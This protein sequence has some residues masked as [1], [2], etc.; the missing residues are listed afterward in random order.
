[1]RKN[2]LSR[3]LFRITFS[4]VSFIAIAIINAAPPDISEEYAEVKDRFSSNSAQTIYFI[5][6]AHCNAEAQM[7]IY[8]IINYLIE[9]KSVELITM[10][11]AEGEIKPDDLRK[12]PYE[13]TKKLVSN[14][15]VKNG[16]I[17][18]VEYYAINDPNPVK[19]LGIEDRELYRKNYENLV[20]VLKN[21]DQGAV[22]DQL[23]KIIKLIKHKIYS[24]ELNELEFLEQSFD[25]NTL[26][27]QDYISKI[28]VL[29]VKKGISPGDYVNLQKC[30]EM[31]Q[32]EKSL[33][34]SAIENERARLVR[35][36]TENMGKDEISEFLQEN[37]KFRLSKISYLN[38]LDYLSK[39]SAD[40]NVDY[41]GFLQ[42]N[43]YQKYLKLHEE[44]NKDRIFVESDNLMERLFGL[45]CAKDSQR[46]IKN[47]AQQAKILR[48]SF[49]LNLTS[50]EWNRL[51]QE[52]LF[53]ENPEDRKFLESYGQEKELHD[54]FAKISEYF[55][56]VKDFYTCAEKRDMVLVENTL[57]DMEKLG[58]KNAVIVAGGYH[59][60]GIAEKLK[61]KN[62]SHYV[63]TA[64]LT[65]EDK[66]NPYTSIVFGSENKLEKFLAGK[67]DA[68]ALSSWLDS[69]PLVVPENKIVFG[70]MFKS[71]LFSTLAWQMTGYDIPSIREL[72]L[73]VLQSVQLKLNE[74]A[75][76]VGYD[77]KVLEI[78]RVN[79]QVYVRL[80]IA[81]QELVYGLF[82]QRNRVSWSS[83]RKAKITSENVLTN[84]QL[85]GGSVLAITPDQYRAIIEAAGRKAV[86]LPEGSDYV[87]RSILTHPFSAHIISVLAV[88]ALDG[89]PVSDIPNAAQSI[90]VSLS[91]M[92]YDEDKSSIEDYLR[93]LIDQF[94]KDGNLK[95]ESGKIKFGQKTV[96]AADI[97]AKVLNQREGIL[98]KINDLMGEIPFADG[99]LQYVFAGNFVPLNILEAL[100]DIKDKLSYGERVGLG[101][102]GDDEFTVEVHKLAGNNYFALITGK[103]RLPEF[104]SLDEVY[105][106]VLGDDTIEVASYDNLGLLIKNISPTEKGLYFTLV[107]Q[108][109]NTQESAGPIFEF[110]LEKPK[111]VDD[112]IDGL[113]NWK[114]KNSV[115]IVTRIGAFQEKYANYNHLIRSVFEPSANDLDELEQVEE[116]KKMIN[117]YIFAAGK[118]MQKTLGVLSGRI[119][120][121]MQGKNPR[122]PAIKAIL[123]R[124]AAFLGKE[125]K[126]DELDL[127]YHIYLHYLNYQAKD[128][129]IKSIDPA[130]LA[131]VIK[132][133]YI[134][135]E[136]ITPDSAQEKLI[137]SL[138]GGK[139]LSKLDF[140]S[141]S[142]KM[143]RDYIS[144]IFS[145][146][147]SVDSAFKNAGLSFFN[148]KRILVSKSRLGGFV[149]D[150][151]ILVE[152]YQGK[153]TILRLRI[154]N[155][156]TLSNLFSRSVNSMQHKT[157]EHAELFPKIYYHHSSL[158]KTPVPVDAS[159]LNYYFAQHVDGIVGD[160]ITTH[161]EEFTQT[162]ILSMKFDAARAWMKFWD[163][164]RQPKTSENALDGSNVILPATMESVMF[165]D[166]GADPMI[167]GIGYSVQTDPVTFFDLLY[168]LIAGL[169]I[170]QNEFIPVFGNAII[171]IFGFE[172]GQELL[173]QALAEYKHNLEWYRSGKSDISFDKIM[174]L[175]RY[176][177][178]SKKLMNRDSVVSLVDVAYGGDQLEAFKH[179]S[180]LA[181]K[182]G[183]MTTDI[184]TGLMMKWKQKNPSVNEAKTMVRRNRPSILTITGGTGGNS[185][186]NA[187]KGL[188]G[189]V[190][191]LVS[192]FDSG[193]QSY[194]WQDILDP[195]FGYVYSRGDVT[196]VSIAYLDEA[197]QDLLNK[198]LPDDRDID[199][200]YPIVGEIIAPTLEKYPQI[201]ESP[202]FLINFIDVVK[203]IDEFIAFLRTKHKEN[204]EKYR[205]ID[206]RKA[207]I[208][209]LFDESLNYF[210]N[211]Y[212]VENGR[213]DMDKNAVAIY[214]AH[215]LLGIDTGV[216]LPISTDEGDLVA[217]L[218]TPI[219]KEE[220][221]ELEREMS[222]GTRLN[223]NLIPQDGTSIFGEHYIGEIGDFIPQFGK[224]IDYLDNVRNPS[225]QDQKP[226]MT[227]QALEA[228][229]YPSLD[230]IMVGP[231]SLFT[232]LLANFTLKEF[233]DGLVNR[234]KSQV[235]TYPN[236]QRIVI[237]PV[238]R[239][240]IMNPVHSPEDRGMSVTDIILMIERTAQKSTGNPSLKFEDM[241]DAVI[242]NDP[243]KSNDIVKEFIRKKNMDVIAPTADDEQFLKSRDIEVYSF[244]MCTIQQRPTRKAGFELA[245]ADKL[246]YSSET[247]KLIGNLFL[248]NV[249][250]Q[251]RE[252]RIN[253]G[254]GH[255][256][257][258][259]EDLERVKN[260]IQQGTVKPL[261]Y[262]S[263]FYK[264]GIQWLEMRL[265]QLENK[266]NREE[267][268]ETIVKLR[269][270]LD[271]FRK[272]LDTMNEKK[273]KIFSI[274]PKDGSKAIFI[275]DA[276]H[277]QFSALIE[278]DEKGLKHGIYLSQGLINTVEEYIKIHNQLIE[279]GNLELSDFYANKAGSIASES[280]FQPFAEWT[281]QQEIQGDFDLFPV[282]K[283]IKQIGEEHI[284]IKRPI[285]G[286]Y[287]Y[288]EM[289]SI[290]GYELV[291]KNMENIYSIIGVS[292]D[293]SIEEKI[294]FLTRMLEKA[295]KTGELKSQLNGFISKLSV[296]MESLLSSIHEIAPVTRDIF[297]DLEIMA[298]LSS[299]GFNSI[300]AMMKSYVK[301][302]GKLDEVFLNDIDS[303]ILY[304]YWISTNSM[305]D[306]IDLMKKE[307]N[308]RLE[309]MESV[310]Q[311]PYLQVSEEL[312][313]FRY[314]VGRLDKM[315]S[316]LRSD[317]EMQN[318]FN[319]LRKVTALQIEETLR[320]LYLQKSIGEASIKTKHDPDTLELAETRYHLSAMKTTELETWMESAIIE[321]ISPIKEGFKGNLKQFLSMFDSMMDNYPVLRD[322][323]VKG[324]PIDATPDQINVV[325][326]LL[327]I[328]IMRD[329]M[330]LAN[331]TQIINFGNALYHP[332][333]T[334]LMIS[335]SNMIS[336]EN[337]IMM[338]YLSFSRNLL[339]DVEQN[340]LEIAKKISG[341]QQKYPK[342]FERFTNILTKRG[343]LIAK[344]IG[345]GDGHHSENPLQV[346]KIILG[347]DVKK[348][349][350]S[351]PLIKGVKEYIHDV[352]LKLMIDSRNSQ[353]EEYQQ[354]QAASTFLFRIY[355]AMD[356]AQ[357]RFWVADPKDGNPGIFIADKDHFQFAS[358]VA[359]DI[360]FSK[361]LIDRL[362]YIWDRGQVTNAVSMMADSIVNLIG[363]RIIQDDMGDS[364]DPKAVHELM[365][366][367]SNYLTTKSPVLDL[368]Q[369]PDNLVF[370]EMKKIVDAYIDFGITDTKSIPLFNYPGDINKLHQQ[371]REK[372]VMEQISTHD[373][374]NIVLEHYKM[375]A[376]LGAPE[377]I[378]FNNG[379]YHPGEVLGRIS[380][381]PQVRGADVTVTHGP[382]AEKIIDLSETDEPSKT[383]AREVIHTL[384]S[385]NRYR[386]FIGT[387]TAH[388]LEDMMYDI[389][390]II[391]TDDNPYE[392]LKEEYN[393]KGM[394]ALKEIENMISKTNDELWSAILVAIAGNALDFADSKA[395]KEISE[396]G[397]YFSQEIGKIL[398]DD[399]HIAKNDYKFL[400]DALKSKPG[401]K[402]IYSID[403]A[404][405]IITDFPLLKRLIQQGHS[406]VLVTRDKHTMNDVSYQDAVKLFAREEV[407]H[408]F[409]DSNGNTLLT[410]DKFKII[411]SGSN[412]TG[413]DLR[414]AN[415]VFIKEWVSADLRLL[416]GQGNYETLR[417]V[418]LKQD[419][420]FLVKVKDPVATENKFAKGD[421]LIDYK[422]VNPLVNDYFGGRI[423][424]VLDS[425]K[426][427]L[428]QDEKQ[429]VEEFIEF[430][431]NYL[432]S[433][434]FEWSKVGDKDKIAT[435]FAQA[436]KVFDKAAS[437]PEIN[438]IFMDKMRNKLQRNPAVENFLWQYLDKEAVQI[439]QPQTNSKS[440]Y[441]VIDLDSIPDN[442]LN[443]AHE[444]L[445]SIALNRK[446][447]SEVQLK[448]V[449]FS[450]RLNTIS[451]MEEL[452]K[453]RFFVP[454][455]EIIGNDKF[456]IYEK[457]WSKSF[458]NLIESV[459][460]Y[461]NHELSADKLSPS[462]VKIISK[463][464]DY[465]R[466]GAS[467]QMF[468][469]KVESSDKLTAVSDF[470]SAV[471]SADSL[472][473]GGKMPNLVVVDTQNG[474]EYNIGDFSTDQSAV[475]LVNYLN[476]KI[477]GLK[478]S[479]PVKEKLREF[480][481]KRILENSI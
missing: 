41:S 146:T 186:I 474:Q 313:N 91:S 38:Y 442:E 392:A 463:D 160:R 107:G 257:Y 87:V 163:L 229:N 432:S 206:L 83:V 457:R 249:R 23:T 190:V 201:K 158:A 93:S 412:V 226:V 422:A 390:R 215:K 105:R 140:S 82:A 131:R 17:N 385:D 46:E 475:V 470:I 458:D 231:G 381:F 30:N 70:N 444:I 56:T 445:N 235:V 263:E 43:G 126:A 409:M 369:N 395:A 11:G 255:G 436:S 318:T 142:E 145:D 28:L 94:E 299:T 241:F 266:L 81:G 79:E 430:Y 339:Q 66:N 220:I 116:F 64:K 426:N 60:S 361:G 408:Y 240:F 286:S 51:V 205:K 343:D 429:I 57:K 139:Y 284:S 406:I 315:I 283:D 288:E 334:N 104:E 230:L 247:L 153:K 55:T 132:E 332:D 217:R 453:R 323:P 473:H 102:V 462:A 197:K 350:D 68:L 65:E 440:Q 137:S 144:W 292:P 154:L 404:G 398:Q 389:I 29:A 308:R 419:S 454:G 322:A 248:T 242:M 338:N 238:K 155:N 417:Y 420:F 2:L 320:V 250:T 356:T 85:L 335:L 19:V 387:L 53:F 198:R 237:E 435:M 265:K 290:V 304:Q 21:G 373:F 44:I 98:V 465:L 303:D 3:L 394:D 346:N 223:R 467:N 152:D 421:V 47:I 415:S 447:V 438:Q 86:S 443:F 293:I 67:W 6:D 169:N 224:N 121:I 388:E 264:K 400:V 34:L 362:N 271:V 78:T 316:S 100:W 218:K 172:K 289:A 383:K 171:S 357:Y 348:L 455:M 112:A 425:F 261:S 380:E 37:M 310:Y 411:S 251:K 340:Y 410:G 227:K 63:L 166:S 61:E 199:Y 382:Y 73:P 133:A 228:L 18:G 295:E 314:T 74:I 7:N 396:R 84:F 134:D 329:N 270:D 138:R 275:D 376:E 269:K 193:G 352:A 239:V 182:R 149:S 157:E 92:K 165:P 341:I 62:I 360:Y 202:E 110:D 178:W 222:M 306:L 117:S 423:D 359:D 14:Y 76:M 281:L 344:T 302:V 258:R 301:D 194:L 401:Q 122:Y 405:E 212:D 72:N 22:F 367:Y 4:T 195:L 170:S 459:H 36:L 375:I 464:D 25:E 349:V 95:I 136:S 181:I 476:G 368:D 274:Q 307:L 324:I 151:K 317:I 225:N 434:V 114:S 45:M 370:T 77:L 213:M 20:T 256:H 325:N 40:H 291:F 331:Y 216:I 59:T 75:S 89:K 48:K 336:R 345:L 42:L 8:K 183:V 188:D 180:K 278:T 287:L 418:P 174:L 312:D 141:I 384:L 211:A 97:A 162:E 297:S 27:L 58:I 214:M 207:S 260:I 279:T 245:Y 219:A 294:T 221:P 321:A 439:I 179:I 15:F 354:M 159:G 31:V 282:H 210:T 298:V 461:L 99:T 351:D 115:S 393:Q 246:E 450:S 5:Q 311:K 129:D 244:D 416:K 69:N 431:L 319:L 449:V 353:A 111:T 161:P 50:R 124:D 267:N 478:P 200:I 119:V 175:I 189:N 327:Q 309:K 366:Q 364:F 106:T 441:I 355:S 477:L 460:Y 466:Y 196:N 446:T 39:L 399:Q 123:S 363:E 12:F 414:R 88:N 377:S 101:K 167:L 49:R 328:R 326:A 374:L 90:A 437:V 127:L 209:N 233:V 391:T 254:I 386:D 125:I 371:L 272:T 296:N 469:I 252:S 103:Q 32:I 253:I 268:N 232:S 378:I 143:Y 35:L 113:Y 191:N 397:F 185:L 342:D 208:K 176:V 10:E 407:K 80:K 428:N 203:K 96:F 480:G 52:K 413:T 135:D 24:P 471:V 333:M 277:Y 150:F 427:G 108:D 109:L 305:I 234:G 330:N 448:W 472:V 236:N 337:R 184:I 118:D 452:L 468:V 479:R 451:I 173:V 372:L 300:D 16:R 285:Y 128:I 130:I 280:L 26:S 433:R 379:Y 358:S 13:E 1:M 276:S 481:F 147:K 54:C 168:S 33:N 262:D 177:T 120:E 403:N 187:I 365:K 148:T 259:P 164:E 402:I 156:D 347:S 424:S 9:S 273:M 71:M 456:M 243:S 204:P 192:T